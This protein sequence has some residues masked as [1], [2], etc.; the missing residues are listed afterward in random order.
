MNKPVERGVTKPVDSIQ[1]CLT[2]YA[3]ALTYEQ[4]SPE[5]V[6]AAKAV[7]VL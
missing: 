4:L 6:H 7:N 2:D 3:C 1:M 5:A